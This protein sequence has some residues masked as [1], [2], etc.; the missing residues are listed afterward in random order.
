[1]SGSGGQKAVA[2]AATRKSCIMYDDDAAAADKRLTPP[3]VP[4][5][6]RRRRAGLDVT[7][8]CVYES[9]TARILLLL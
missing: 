4:L 6:L 7:D 2:V 3:A 1:M 5:H 8:D 9:Y